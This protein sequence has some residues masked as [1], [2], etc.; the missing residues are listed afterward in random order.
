VV[1]KTNGEYGSE[2][3]TK[4]IPVNVSFEYKPLDVDNVVLKA[5]TNIT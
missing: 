5:T 2:N 3:A 4:S 1:L